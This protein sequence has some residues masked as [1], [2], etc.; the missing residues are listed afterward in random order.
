M[1]ALG[2]GYS[3]SDLQGNSV[4]WPS[5]STEEIYGGDGQLVRSAYCGV[6]WLVAQS[7]AQEVVP[8]E[9]L[10]DRQRQK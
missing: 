4:S 9:L 7:L 5:R 2:M 10:R 1:A 3:L 6:P 8:P